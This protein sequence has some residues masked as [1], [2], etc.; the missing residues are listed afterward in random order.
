MSVLETYPELAELDFRVLATDIDPK[1]VEFGKVGRYPDR[2][3]TGVPKALRKKYFVE[4][5]GEDEPVFRVN[6]KFKS[7]VV[8]K[9]LNLLS[10][11]P[12]KNTMD[13]IFCR[14][15]VIYFDVDTQNRLWPRFRRQLSDEG[16]LFL[17]HSE[18]IAEPVSAGFRNDGP[19]CYRPANA[20]NI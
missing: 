18:R 7:L 5:T 10:E 15:V 3:L 16:F 12:M 13:V 2:L 11:W 6:E 4:D 8:F 19:T 14:N 1:V 9:E 20:T 17:G